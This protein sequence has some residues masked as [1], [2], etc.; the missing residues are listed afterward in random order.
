[1]APKSIN[2]RKSLRNRIK[3]NVEFYIDADIIHSE[4]IN[5]S[6]NGLQFETEKPMIVK[7]RFDSDGIKKESAAKLIWSKQENGNTIYGLEY[8][9]PPNIGKM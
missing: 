4:T 1:M 5:I 8:I 9:S 2:Q 3:T 6:K 7:M